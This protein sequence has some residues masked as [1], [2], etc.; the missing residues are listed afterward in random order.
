MS[1]HIPYHNLNPYR[2][3]PSFRLSHDV[4]FRG[5]ACVVKFNP[6][7]LRASI[8]PRED[9]LSSLIGIAKAA[10]NTTR[11]KGRI[12]YVRRCTDDARGGC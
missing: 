4:E 5:D 9:T 7:L 11:K 10:S 6:V 2:T 1:R 8:V 3:V 12:Q